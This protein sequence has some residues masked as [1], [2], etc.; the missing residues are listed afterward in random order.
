MSAARVFRQGLVL[1]LADFRQFWGVRSWLGGWMLR[2]STNA[3][4]WVLLG[5]LL[6]SE[7]R[8]HYLLVGNAVATGATA[9]LWASNSVTW[10]RHD[11]THPL[12]V[13]APASALPAAM[14]RAA[15]W[16][17][18]GV[19]T[20]L[21]SFALLLA[22]F[23]YRP[24]LPSAWLTLPIVVVVCA[25]SYCFALFMGSLVSLRP[26]LR[27]GALDLSSMAC[28][29]LCGVSVPVNFW[30]APVQVLAELLPLTHGLA[31]IRSLLGVGPSGPVLAPV[32]LELAVGAGWLVAASL[33]MDRLAEAGRADGS[34]ERA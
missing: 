28:L 6:G 27:I 15:V 3:Y 1:G 7:E 2:V 14:G 8:L 23:D 18:N 25:S 24:P 11:G 10:N 32:A 12:Q 30:P 16:L 34:I 26:E 9:A 29:A 31:A 13:I 33:C 19:L 17:V 20:S 5:R 21:A 22:A 4:A